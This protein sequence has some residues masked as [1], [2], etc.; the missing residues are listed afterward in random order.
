MVVQAVHRV[1]LEIVQRVVHPAHVPLERK[2]ESAGP[3]RARHL[4]PGG[5]LL[6]N[7]Q[8]A[9]VLALHH[10]AHLAQ[11]LDRLQVLVA[12][13][14]VRQPLPG[15]ARVVQVQHG[16]DRVHAQAVRVE[17]LHPVQ[18]RADQEAPHLGAAEVEHQRAPVRVLAQARVLVLVQ[19][20]AVEAGERVRVLRKVR[21]HPVQ[22]HA[23]AGLVQAVDQQAKAVRVAV[24]GGRREIAGALVAPG[25][26]ERVLH[27]RQQLD[28]REAQIN[29]VRHQLV[30]DFG[31]TEKPAVRRPAPGTEMQLV[32]ADRLAVPVAGGA[33]FEPGPIAPGVLAGR[34]HATGRGRAQL[35]GAGAGVGLQQQALRRAQLEL[36]QRARRD[37][38]DEQLPHTA[39]ATISHRM[40]AAVPAVPVTDHR[41]AVGVRRPH[42]KQ[43]AVHAVH[44]AQVRAQK[45][46]RVPVPALREQ[47]QVEVRQQRREAVRVDGAMFLAGAVAPAQR[48]MGR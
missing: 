19:R 18:R 4:R 28:V 11:E 23:D 14:A 12:A 33:A 15:F 29:H 41:H 36:V 5:G 34:H 27:H 48:V 16:G 43:H 44:P 22:D 35:G 38:G 30:G 42:G 6:G 45:V 21:R 47:V 20:R 31:V 40:P 10:A 32:D 3:R 13:V 37:A 7:H 1:V 46:L 17:G 2:A 39:V 26:V 24:A 9:R 8:R 25:G